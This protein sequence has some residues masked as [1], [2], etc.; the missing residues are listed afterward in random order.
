MWYTHYNSWANINNEYRPT[1]D[2]RFA[3]S[4]DGISWEFDNKICIFPKHDN[5][6]LGAPCVRKIN[7]LYH[8]WYGYRDNFN[9]GEKYKMGYAISNDKLDWN[10]LDNNIINSSNQGWDSEMVCYPNILTSNNQTMMFY[11]GNGYGKEG[12]GYAILN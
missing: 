10:R 12:F 7:D 11:S 1:Y 8:M 2:I 6:V 5:E 4:S 9:K 3:K